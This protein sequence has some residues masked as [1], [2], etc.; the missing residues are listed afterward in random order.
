MLNKKVLLGSLVA[1]AMLLPLTA[2]A[3]VVS[4][5]CVNCHTMHATDG[6]GNN[7]AN[8]NAQLTKGD[9]CAGCHAKGLGN[10]GTTGV[11]NDG[12]YSA[13]QVDDA[14]N[15]NLAGYFTTTGDTLTEWNQQHNVPDSITG[16]SV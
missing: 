4:G 3:G 8:Q 5:N 10:T 2:S 12:G 11:V 13:P 14:A 7:F 6:A 16:M 1:G 15:P 9:S